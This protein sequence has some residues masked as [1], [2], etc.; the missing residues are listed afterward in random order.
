M[1]QQISLESSS[2][3]RYRP[4]V[5]DDLVE[6]IYARA[7]RLRGLRL[8]HVNATAHGGGVAEIL[9]SLVPLYRGLGIEVA[10]LVMQ[11]DKPFFQFTKQLHNA[12]Q[13]AEPDFSQDGWERYMACNRSS[14][15]A[16]A[17]GYDAVVLHDP[18]PV[19]MRQFVEGG[20]TR[21]VWRCHI[22]TSH[23][24]DEA[25]S[26]VVSQANKFDAVVFSM[27]EFVGPGIRGPRIAI[28]PPAIDPVAPKNQPM[29]P[30][31]AARVISRFGV[32]PKRPFITQV[33]RFDPWKDPLGVIACFRQLRDRHPNLQLVLLGDFPI[34]DPEGPVMYTKVLKAAEAMPDIH[35]ITGLTDLVNPFQ[36]LSRV[37]L[38]KSVREGF[39]LTVSEALWKGTPVV[40]GNVGG[41]RLQI[42]D[43]VGGFLVDS[44]KECVRRVHYL[45]THEQERLA[46]GEAGREHVRRSFLLPRL[47]RDELDLLQELIDDPHGQAAN[48]SSSSVPQ[49]S[50]R[51]EESPVT[52]GIPTAAIATT[53]LPLRSDK[54]I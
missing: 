19:A 20:A 5:G 11:E 26:V 35:I 8:A 18:Q 39:G 42:V 10:W 54:P 41:I 32:D 17:A 33:S 48:A 30:E 16:L 49:T 44:V 28:I 12:L 7:S 36:S 29:P 15:A 9:R 50:Q 31:E 47:L 13:G 43:G 14:A 40:A 25:W 24:A 6:E 2:L 21:W 4:L 51:I 53:S 45:L 23:P 38:Q 46:L 34:D 27:P 3:E 37:V 52:S 22:D 1:L